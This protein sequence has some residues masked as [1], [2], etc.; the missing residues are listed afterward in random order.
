M[1]Q[2]IFTKSHGFFTSVD[3]QGHAGFADEG[4]DIVC[5]AISSAVQ[6][7]HALLFDVRH[8]AVDALVEDDGAHIRLTLPPDHL[9]EG[10]DA[11]AALHLHFT[12]LMHDYAAFINVTEVH[13][14]A[15]N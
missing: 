6:L 1:T 9:A 2:V 15:E 3:L 13:N 11:L 5:A 8:I 7:T 10:H 4:E 12:E 14:D